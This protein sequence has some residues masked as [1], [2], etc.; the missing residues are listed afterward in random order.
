VRNA[1]ARQDTFFFNTESHTA[2]PNEGGFSNFI[3]NTT[4]K[5][6]IWILGKN[7]YLKRNAYGKNKMNE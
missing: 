3:R 4:K 2:F 7:N 5:V 1:H 6:T